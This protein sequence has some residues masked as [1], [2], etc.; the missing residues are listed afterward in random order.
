MN[1]PVTQAQVMTE[2]SEAVEWQIY[3][4]IYINIKQS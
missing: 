4:Y 1:L 2:Y 3:I